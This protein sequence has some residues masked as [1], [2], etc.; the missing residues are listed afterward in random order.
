MLHIIL[1]E[2]EQPGNIGAIARAMKNFELKNLVLINPKCN[3]LDT[4]ARN[5]AKHAQD[6]LKK[7]KIVKFVKQKNKKNIKTFL[8]KYHTKIATTSQ[9]GTDYNIPR[10]PIT[11]EQLA[12]IIEKRKLKT[13]KQKIALVFGREGIGLTNQEIL[14][15]DFIVNIPATKKYPTLNIAQSAVILFYEL[16][17]QKGKK[18][19]EEKYKLASVKDKQQIEKMLKQILDELSFDTNYKKQTQIKVWKRIFGKSFLTK[20]EAFAVMGLLR[21]LLKKL[22]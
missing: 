2:P 17:K 6:I 5:R 12:E 10:S 13:T 15:C 8:K 21:K 14:E 22:K 1:I 18:Q 4:E 7:A 11:P 16:F 3:H 9:L 20:R 19:I